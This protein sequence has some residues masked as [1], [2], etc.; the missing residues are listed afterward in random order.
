VERDRQARRGLDE[1]RACRVDLAVGGERADDDASR[2][3]LPCQ[4]DVPH[5]QVKLVPVVVEVT[6]TRADEDVRLD[7]R[8]HRL[9]EGRTR[10]EPT[11]GQCRAQLD[12]GRA[13][14]GGGPRTP[15]RLHTDLHS[16]D[17][18]YRA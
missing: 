2:A 17:H 4:H 8:R 1:R 7:D 14:L 11:V 13:G 18:E 5:H 16:H 10:G 9:D 6:G 3:V 12:P 15:Q